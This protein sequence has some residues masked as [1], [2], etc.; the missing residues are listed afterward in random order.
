M[1]MHHLLLRGMLVGL[2]AGLLA[3]AFARTFGEPSVERAIAFEAAAAQAK[4]EAPEPA[5]VSRRVQAS[6]GLATGVVVYGAAL[7]GL[8]SLVFALCYGRVGRLSSRGCAALLAGLGF[9]TLAVVPA[10]KYP[11]NPP[12]IGEP[13]TIGLR[14]ALY[15]SMI[16]VSLVSLMVA[17]SLRRLA[18]A[19]LGSW[20]AT[21][22]GAGAFVLMVAVAC[23]ALPGVDEVPA[24]FPA[25]TLWRFRLASLGVQAVMWSVLGL[26][27]GALTE[28]RLAGRRG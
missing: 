21:L 10:L 15:L 8:F 24:E 19:R 13:G 25:T 3:F 7:G 1:A 18:L 2:L 16:V 14:T 22:L 27:F 17:A 20:D 26:L 28:R 11:A 5:M 4:G 6:V 23:L 9:L 12:S